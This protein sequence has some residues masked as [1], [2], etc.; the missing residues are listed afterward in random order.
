MEPK[1]PVKSKTVWFNVLTLM[2]I[3]MAA[4]AD[5]NVISENPVLVGG[6]AVASAVV[7]L[8]LRMVTKSPL[9]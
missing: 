4:V 7:N 3:A 5:H 6:V 2:G 8:L 1:S 9:S